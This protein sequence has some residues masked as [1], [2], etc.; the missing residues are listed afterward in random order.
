MA[1]VSRALTESGHRV[2]EQ[3]RRQIQLLADELGYRPNLVARGLRTDRTY[4]V[5]LIV[6]SIATAFRPLI[7]RGIQD[8]LKELNY[9]SVVINADW[10]PEIETEAHS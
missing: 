10:D 7:I 9:F 4:T 5:G 2:N 8:H 3:T 6:D 1:T